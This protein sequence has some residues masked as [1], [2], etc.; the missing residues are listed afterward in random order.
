MDR[1]QPTFFLSFRI[2]DKGKTE[3]VFSIMGCTCVAT[4]ALMLL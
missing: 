1:L 3:T 4:G 2:R